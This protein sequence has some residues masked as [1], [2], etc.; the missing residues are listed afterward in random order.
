V[1]AGSGNSLNW[2][3]GRARPERGSASRSISDFFKTPQIDP[4]SSCLAMLLQ[5]ADPRF[6][7]AAGL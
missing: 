5:V 3:A 6:G 2:P 1:A 7:F 4:N